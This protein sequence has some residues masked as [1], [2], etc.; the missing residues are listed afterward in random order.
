MSPTIEDL[1]EGA[2][3]DAFLVGVF[4]GFWVE[5]LW[6]GLWMIAVWVRVGFWSRQIRY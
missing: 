2:I 3:F 5:S 1:K 4:F 6:A